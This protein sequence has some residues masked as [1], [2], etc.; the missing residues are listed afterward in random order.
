MNGAREG[1]TPTEILILKAY[2]TSIHFIPRL[3]TIF[4]TSPRR[5]VR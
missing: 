5:F 2:D 4:V 1:T 3:Q